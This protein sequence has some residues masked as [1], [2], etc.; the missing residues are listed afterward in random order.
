MVAAA[1][2]DNASN[3]AMLASLAVSGLAVF[4]APGA[5]VLA[6]AATPLRR[7]E[8]P[9]FAFAASLVLLTATFAACLLPGTSIAAAPGVLAVVTVGAALTARRFATGPR[10]GSATF[11]GAAGDAADSHGSRSIAPPPFPGSTLVSRSAL[12]VLTLAFVL[13]A[14]AFAPVG[15]VDRWWYLAYVR[16]Y[17]DAPVLTLA[18][19]FLGTGQ[20]FARFGMH[21]WLFGLATWSWLSGVDPVVVYE[22]GAP[23]LVVLA[24]VSA[25][26]ALARE[27]FGEGPR[28]RLCVLA[29]MLLWSGAMIPVLARAGEDKVLAAS[30]LLPLCIAAFLRVVRAAGTGAGSSADGSDDAV[31]AQS[32]GLLARLLPLFLA[33]VAT[34]AVHALAYAFVLVALLPTA[35]LVAL[36]EPR[37]RRAVGLAST[38]LLLVALAPAVSGIVVRERLSNIGAEL[39]TPDHPVVRVHEGRERLIEL[40]MVGHVV[41]PRLLLHPLALLSLLGMAVL[42]RREHADPSLAP[43]P[44]RDSTKH[45]LLATTIVPLVIAFVPPLPAIAGAVIP[46]WM[47]YRVLWLLPLAPLAAL[48]VDAFAS[49]YPHRESVAVLLLLALGLPAVADGARGRL[50]EVRGRLA[51]PGNAEFRDVIDAI[52]SLPRDALVVA[53]PELSERLPAFTARH[54]VAALDRSTIVFTGSRER[55]E[56][57]LRV[58]AALLAGDADGFVL[59]RDAGLAPTHAIFDPR[60]LVRPRCGALLYSGL[61]YAL[62]ELAT[63]G[64]GDERAPTLERTDEPASHAIGDADCAA[65]SSTSRRDPWAAAPPVVSC[66]IV[67]PSE[68]RGSDDL[69]LLLE[70]NTGRAADELRV[71]TRAVGTA[72]GEYRATVRTSGEDAIALRLPRAEADT[73]EVRI[74]SSFLPAVR[75]RRV[76]LAAR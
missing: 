46:P 23:V 38:M 21:P 67:I 8:Y 43:P 9:A 72:T 39:G 1:L 59:A 20:A 18:E 31:A 70:A 60:A 11:A 52:A 63:G 37:Q 47:V 64:S 17:L 22:R 58:R 4:V 76:A 62:C 56:A 51:A 68:W 19:P 57:R 44:M 65:T 53:A 2:A 5:I 36:R 69:L 50:A 71:T 66:R 14:V 24:S 41:S 27:L 13:A 54:V 55:G 16:G 34:A 32:R 28:A 33:A 3:L 48:A 6:A 74:A 75:P 73:I 40:P 26:C 61:A 15:S 10:R 45:F 7:A 12:V 49:R 42:A 35:A 25:A 30:A 29:T